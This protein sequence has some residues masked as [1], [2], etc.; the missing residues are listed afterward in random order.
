MTY[1][2]VPLGLLWNYSTG[3]KRRTWITLAFNSRDHE[4]RRVCLYT[5]QQHGSNKGLTGIALHAWVHHTC[6][7][8]QPDSRVCEVH[9]CLFVAANGRSSD[10]RMLEPIVS[11]ISPATPL[12][13][14]RS[15]PRWITAFV[16]TDLIRPNSIRCSR[17]KEQQGLAH[18]PSRYISISAVIVP[19]GRGGD[20]NGSI[21]PGPVGTSS[22]QGACPVRAERDRR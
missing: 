18:D 3:L 10:L 8:L 11:Q 9:L 21:Q 16:L 2:P 4:F 1:L 14:W 12:P 6:N 7:A 19:R 20:N 15:R 17:G 5:Q 22:F 13:T